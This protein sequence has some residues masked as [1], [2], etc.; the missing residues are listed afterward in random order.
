MLNAATRH[1]WRVA[2]RRSDS[3]LAICRKNPA[4]RTF[5]RQR[6]GWKAAIA[7]G[8]LG[9][10]CVIPLLA[11]SETA[12]YVVTQKGQAFRPGTLS[13]HRGETV[14]IVN[15]DGELI[16]HAYVDSKAFSFD[17]GDQEPGSKTDIVFSV[18]GDFI[19]LCG[20]H[21]KMRLDVSVK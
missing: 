6:V 18:P 10:A 5:G 2:T 9:L 14:Q 21:P 17:S 13:I 19:V 8:T 7:L 20:I 3:A 4:E 11:G 1:F 15:D 16:H 12:S